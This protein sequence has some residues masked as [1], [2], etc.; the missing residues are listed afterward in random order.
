MLVIFFP[1]RRSWSHFS[2][3]FQLLLSD[4]KRHLEQIHLLLGMARFQ[5]RRDA[6][7]GVPAGVHDMF[8][9][10]VLGFVEQGLNARLGEA[11]GAGVEGF[12]LAPDDGLGVG[13]G[14]E[15]LAEL[16]PRE[17][18]ELLDARDG[19]VA[20]LLGRAVFVERDV[21]LA[22]AEDD[23]LDR[24]GLINGASG[25]FGIGDDPLKVGVA[26][27]VFDRGTSERMAKERFREE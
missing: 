22:G 2:L 10:V 7:A 24:R 19:R 20:D 23:A 14:V 16:S 27:K 3:P 12:F 15:V 21:D 5:A 13:V 4:A 8:A 25:V 11:P 17:R 9:V 1:P 6:R 18:V 26:G